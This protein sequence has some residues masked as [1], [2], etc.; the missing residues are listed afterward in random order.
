MKLAEVPEQEPAV[1]RQLNIRQAVPAHAA[2]ARGKSAGGESQLSQQLSE[3]KDGFSHSVAL[4]LLLLLA[5]TLLQRE[6]RRRC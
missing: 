3:R 4:S 2:L 5:P 1:G 6:C